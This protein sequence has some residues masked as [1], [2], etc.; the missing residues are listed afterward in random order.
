[1]G[2]KSFDELAEQELFGRVLPKDNG[3]KPKL[4]LDILP[5]KS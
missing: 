4:S 2:S 3:K 5:E 1:M